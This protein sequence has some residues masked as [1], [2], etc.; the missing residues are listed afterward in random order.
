MRSFEHIRVLWRHPYNGWLYG[1][2]YEMRPGQSPTDIFRGKGHREPCMNFIGDGSGRLVSGERWVDEVVPSD[3]MLL[4][5]SDP[6][7]RAW[8]RAVEDRDG[9]GTVPCRAYEWAAINKE[10]H[11][12]ERH[13]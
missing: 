8:L 12:N 4:S 9:R 6:Q 11:P 5:E 7:T 2:P 10:S 3:W 13:P 1:V